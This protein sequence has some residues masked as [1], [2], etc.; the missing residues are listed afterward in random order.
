MHC[1][2]A[3]PACAFLEQ[4][5]KA[6]SVDLR[7]ER[8]FDFRQGRRIFVPAADGPM[9]AE[10]PI[11]TAIP[12]FLYIPM[13]GDYFFP[14]LQKGVRVVRHHVTTVPDKWILFNTFTDLY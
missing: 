9:T 1:H 4:P 13:S 8:S 3:I 7:F 10:N 14:S 11:K 12:D 5:L 2:C 6:N